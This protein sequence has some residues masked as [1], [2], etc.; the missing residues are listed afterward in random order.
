MHEKRQLVI[1][2]HRSKFFFRQLEFGATLFVKFVKQ[3]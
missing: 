1:A 3:Q 2:F